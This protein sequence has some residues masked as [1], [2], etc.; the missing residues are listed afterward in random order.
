[1]IFDMAVSI[2]IMSFGIYAGIRLLQLKPNA[3]RVAKRYLITFF[4][5]TALTVSLIFLANVV[6]HQPEQSTRDFGSQLRNIIYVLIWYSYLD[7]SKRVAATYPPQ[8]T[9]KKP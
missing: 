5:Y 2:A 9:I 8:E 3:V 6:N 4:V 7:K 1:L